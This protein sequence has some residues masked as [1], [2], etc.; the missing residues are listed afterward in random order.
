MSSARAG[1]AGLPVS[2]PPKVRATTTRARVLRVLERI[3]NGELVRAS[4]AAEEIDP[5][6]LYE[7]RDT[8]DS[9]AQHYAR[10]R[11]MQIDAIAEETIGIADNSSADVQMDSNGQLRVNTE[12]VARA[13]LRFDARRWYLAALAPRQFGRT[14]NVDVTSAGQSITVISGVPERLCVDAPTPSSH[15]LQPPMPAD[16]TN[17][18]THGAL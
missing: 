13:R 9:N 17:T 15:R 1:T 16:A 8:S 7:W 4:C 18:N 11:E 5:K 3:S 12:V 2:T 14:S 6:R 10:V